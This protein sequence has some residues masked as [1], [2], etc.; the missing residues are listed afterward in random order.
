MNK[1]IQEDVMPIEIKVVITKVGE[2]NE[3]FKFFFPGGKSISFKKNGVREVNSE[4]A[5]NNFE[6]RNYWSSCNYEYHMPSVFRDALNCG[7]LKTTRKQVEKFFVFCPP[8]FVSPKTLK[9]QSLLL[10]LPA[11]I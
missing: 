5:I 1:I 11:R 9:Q 7:G 4:I 2:E 10:T 6:N 3:L 8:E